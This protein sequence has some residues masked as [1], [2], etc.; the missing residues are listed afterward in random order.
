MGQ[1]HP[2]HPDNPI[3]PDYPDQPEHPDHLPI[4]FSKYALNLQICK[5]VSRLFVKFSLVLVFLKLTPGGVLV[6]LKSW[7]ATYK[8]RLM[9]LQGFESVR[10]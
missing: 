9:A 4:S 5:L 2:D 8:V 3:Y 6:T 1:I 10:T 7:E